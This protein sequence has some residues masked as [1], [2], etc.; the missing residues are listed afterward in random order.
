[1]MKQTPPLSTYNVKPSQVN[2]NKN[3]RGAL[4]LG[5]LLGL[6][7]NTV[8]PALI[9]A[10]ARPHMSTAN[11]LF[12]ASVVPGVFTLGKLIVKKRV[13]AVGVLVTVGLLVTAVFALLFKSPRLLLLQNFAAGGLF[14]AVMLISLLL[15]RPFFFYFLRSIRTQSDPESFAIFNA[16]WQSFPRFRSFYRMLTV[17]WGCI[18]VAQLPLLAVLVFTLPISRTSALSPILSFGILIAVIYW[19]IHYT[20]KHT[21]IFEQVRQ[22]RLKTGV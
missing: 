17:V 15:P 11:A 21:P 19:T 3:K 5:M 9:T 18:S 8:A 4:L 2:H 12:L 13:D 7:I 6:L 10:L 16:N 1:M 20:R 22:Q 14:G